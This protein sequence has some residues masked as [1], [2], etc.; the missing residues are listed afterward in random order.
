ME[1]DITFTKINNLKSRSS[2][3]FKE[4]IDRVA[5]LK[6]SVLLIGETGV[7]K[8]FWAEYIYEISDYKKFLNLNCGDV[9]ENLIESEWFG[10]KKGAFTGADVDYEGIRSAGR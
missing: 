9:P 8:D 10:H 3:S 6:N 1:K 5:N 7:G 4:R 2:L